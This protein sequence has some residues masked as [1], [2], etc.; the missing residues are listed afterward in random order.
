MGR[1]ERSVAGQG[2]AYSLFE[3]NILLANRVASR[4]SELTQEKDKLAL[5][6][7]ALPGQIII[8][9]DQLKVIGHFNG[10][11]GS[12]TIEK[13]NDVPEL[14]NEEFREKV[15]RYAR[16]RDGTVEFFEFRDETG[17]YLSC[18]LSAIDPRQSV[19]YMFDNTEKKNQEKLIREQESQL[20]QASKL[21]AI[22]QMAGGMAHEINTPLSYILIRAEQIIDKLEQGSPAAVKD[23]ALGIVKTVERISLIIKGLRSFSRDAGGDPLEE[24][25]VTEIIEQTLNLC[26]EKVRIQG[27]D[28]RIDPFPPQLRVSCRS[29]QIQQVLLN[30]LNNSVD[31][32]KDLPEKWIRISVREDLRGTEIRITDSGPGIPAEIHTKLFQPFFTTK[33]VGSGTGLGLSISMGVMKSHG[34]DLWL[35][36]SGAHTSF[37]LFL[38]P[39]PKTA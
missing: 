4:T 35:D 2:T 18:S 5:I 20:L 33:P 14:F 26:R 21:S 13:G 22:G 1:V 25:A 9:D 38:P 27:V 31:A 19:L 29:I 30:L 24:V 7:R 3:E 39:S 16:K 15:L 37:V 11:H 28:L 34:G 32:V 12:S 10:S 6:L 36:S 23:L 8:F 17:R